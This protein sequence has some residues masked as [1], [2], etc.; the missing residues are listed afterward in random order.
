MKFQYFPNL[1]HLIAEFYFFSLG[2]YFALSL[3][4]DH[5]LATVFSR[6]LCSVVDS[7]VSITEITDMRSKIVIFS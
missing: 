7:G 1:D 6:Y 5:C 3:L 4:S 2:T